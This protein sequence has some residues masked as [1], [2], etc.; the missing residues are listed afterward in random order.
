MVTQTG[1]SV[2]GVSRVWAIGSVLLA[3]GYT[4]IPLKLYFRNGKAKLEI[5]LA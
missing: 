1:R 2:R 5:G 4:L 3:K